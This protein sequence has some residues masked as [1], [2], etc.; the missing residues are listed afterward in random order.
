M[1]YLG[2]IDSITDLTQKNKYILGYGGNVCEKLY[3]YFKI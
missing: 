1:N 3:K 2:N